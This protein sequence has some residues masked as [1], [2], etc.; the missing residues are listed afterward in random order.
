MFWAAQAM[1]N[2]KKPAEKGISH[3]LNFIGELDE[4]RSST[5]MEGIKSNGFCAKDSQFC[6]KSLCRTFQSWKRMWKEFAFENEI[7]RY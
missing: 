6:K 4:V 3:L 7:R 2:F 1:P 5:N